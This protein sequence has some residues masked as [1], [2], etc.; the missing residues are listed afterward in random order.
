MSDGMGKAT[1]ADRIATRGGLDP[2]GIDGI[3]AAMGTLPSSSP[4]RATR[5]FRGVQGVGVD[6]VDGPR[7]PYKAI[8][9]VT[10]ATWGNAWATKKWNAVTAEA[11]FFVVREALCGRQPP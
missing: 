6:Y 2:V 9:A 4:P 11:R 1:L 7:N 10:A 3:R 5:F 8:F